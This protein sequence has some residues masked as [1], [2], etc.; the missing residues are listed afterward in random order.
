MPFLYKSAI[1]RVNGVVC[2]ET[3]VKFSSGQ[4]GSEEGWQ[5]ICRV[6]A[7]LFML[8]AVYELVS[9]VYCSSLIN[10]TLGLNS[11]IYIYVFWF[12]APVHYVYFVQLV[13]LY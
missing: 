12:F 13:D 9:T 6:N 5:G 2:I 11:H 3:Y 7:F 4:Q 8:F 1:L 10:G